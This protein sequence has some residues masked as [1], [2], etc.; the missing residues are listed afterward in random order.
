MMNMMNNGHGGWMM[1]GIGLLHILFWGLIIVGAVLVIQWF[2]GRR[3]ESA[4]EIL[5]K[6]YAKGEIDSV[7]FERMKKDI[8]EGEES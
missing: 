5:N 7:A 3:E 2:S 4:K 6:R 1:G 8:D